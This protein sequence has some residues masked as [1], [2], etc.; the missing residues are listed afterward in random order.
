MSQQYHGLQTQ[1]SP[2]LLYRLHKLIL[3]LLGVWREEGSAALTKAQEVQSEDGPTLRENI[4]VLSPEAH[5]TSKPMEQN[6]GGFVF[7]T[8]TSKDQGPQQVAARDGDVLSE[9]STVY[10]CQDSEERN[11]GVKLLKKSKINLV[12][13]SFNWKGKI[14][15][16]QLFLNSYTTTLW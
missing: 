7:D 1:F 10:T 14:N 15:T 9:K 3:C 12:I 11:E 2:P 16:G 6:H 13:I 4:Q 8:V 5:A